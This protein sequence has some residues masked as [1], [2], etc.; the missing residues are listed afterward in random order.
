MPKEKLQKNQKYWLIV[1]DPYDYTHPT[2]GVGR[3]LGEV[4]DVSDKCVIFKAAA[5]VTIRNVQGD[6][7]ILLNRYKGDS[8]DEVSTLAGVGLIYID[9]AHYRDVKVEYVMIGALEKY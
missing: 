7:F 1:S 9:E 3:I 5:P 8:I 4:L 2:Y 6:I